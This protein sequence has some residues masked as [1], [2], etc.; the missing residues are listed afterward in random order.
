MYDATSTAL[1]PPT[2]NLV[3]AIFE[4]EFIH[5]LKRPPVLLVGGL[6]AW[7]REVG[8][9][10]IVRGTAVGGDSVVVN[11][12]KENIP[13]STAST[14]P[15]VPEFPNTSAS[16]DPHARWVPSSRPRAGTQDS[17]VSGTRERSRTYYSTHTP[18]R[19]VGLFWISW[20]CLMLFQFTPA[21][22]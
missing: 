12:V 1:T 5:S 11:G 15:I 16:T 13:E 7:K 2:S 4:T 22:P 17:I 19:F 3:R 14:G 9:Q 20:R 18:A 10:G 8:D 21:S 6:E